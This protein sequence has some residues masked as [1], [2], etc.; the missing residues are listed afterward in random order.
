MLTAYSWLVGISRG[1]WCR[2]HNPGRRSGTAGRIIFFRTLCD[3]SHII[4]FVF[5]PPASRFD[6][7]KAPDVLGRQRPGRV[8]P[9][10]V[11]MHVGLCLS[12]FP[13]VF[14]ELHHEAHAFGERLVAK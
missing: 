5:L 8:F 11:G 9:S 12:I 13:F 4:S 10:D 1:G 7:K 2:V 14:C 3:F 6:I